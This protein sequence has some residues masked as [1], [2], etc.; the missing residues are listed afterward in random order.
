MEKKI[1]PSSEE[2]NDLIKFYD[3]QETA[4][5]CGENKRTPEEKGGILHE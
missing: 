1:S 3:F 2:E 5:I 4:F